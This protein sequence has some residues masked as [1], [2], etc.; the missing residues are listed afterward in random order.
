MSYDDTIKFD[1]FNKKQSASKGSTT[2]SAVNLDDLMP[3]IAV[4]GIGGA[5][6][7]TVSALNSKFRD[8]INFVEFFAFNT[9]VQSLKC[10][11][12]EKQLVLGAK[13]TKGKGAGANPMVG[14]QAALDSYDEI[15]MALK[16]YQNH[17]VIITA[18]F[19]G[20]TGTGATEI[21]AQA[22]RELGAL[23]IAI[24][25]KP[26][27]FEGQHRMNVAVEGIRSL[28][29]HVDT[30]IICSNDRL[31]QCSE[32]VMSLKKAFDLADNFLS[33]CIMNFVSIIQEPGKMNIDFADIRRVAQDRRSI[34]MFGSGYAEGEGCGGW[35]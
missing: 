28:K 30:L 29:Q 27:Q 26:F 2:L 17:M 7:N 33:E 12:C 8:D 21:V 18:G 16:E 15:A 24:V 3:R 31:R 20:G 9:D 34:G 23:T 5:G 6:S 13:V 1:D 25:T 19:G 4:V 35:L 32:G 11:S 14:R 22:A 10:C